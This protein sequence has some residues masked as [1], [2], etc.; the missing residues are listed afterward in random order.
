MTE[1]DEPQEPIDLDKKLDI[2]KPAGKY[3]YYALF[4][5]PIGNHDPNGWVQVGR[6]TLNRNF[7]RETFMPQAMLDS[8]MYGI[9]WIDDELG[10]TFKIMQ[11]QVIRSNF[12]AESDPRQ[13]V[14]VVKYDVI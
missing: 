10:M 8:N 9:A 3:T 5:R 13:K 11:R 14:M 7:L 2:R 1:I 12:R 6:E 4:R